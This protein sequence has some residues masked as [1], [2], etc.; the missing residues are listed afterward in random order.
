LERADESSAFSSATEGVA[1]FLLR[2]CFLSA[3]GDLFCFLDGVDERGLRLED[4]DG[5][6]FFLLPDSAAFLG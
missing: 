3:D 1:E 2:T 5:E 6:V 4:G